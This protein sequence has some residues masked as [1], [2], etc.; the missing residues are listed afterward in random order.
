M[1]DFGSTF[2]KLVAVD[3][4]KEDII[5]TSSHF[6]TVNDD[7]TIGY[8]NALNLLYKKIGEEIKFDKIISCSS[9]AG[10]LKMAAKEKGRLR[11]DCQTNCVLPRSQG[12]VSYERRVR[13]CRIH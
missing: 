11:R 1:I 3:S 12:G 4:E 8:K 13:P 6:T 5:A 7:I 10:G 9:A 2:T